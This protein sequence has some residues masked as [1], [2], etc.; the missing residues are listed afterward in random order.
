MNK[1]FKY[2]LYPNKSQEEILMKN[3]GCCRW[4]YNYYLNARQT[5][6]KN[7]EK[8]KHISES[9]LKKEFDW[10]KDAESTSLQ[11]SRIDL[12]T[13]YKNFFRKIKSK[14][15]TSLRYKSKHF[16]KRTFRIQNVRNSLRV[17]NSKIKLGKLGFIKL[18]YHRELEGIIKSATVEK[19]TNKWF[20]SIIVEC[21]ALIKL[22]STDKT[23]G[24]DLGLKEF[25]T[26]SDG[27]VIENP[28]FLKSSEEKL[29]REQKKLSKRKKGSSNRRKQQKVVAKLHEKIRNQRSD[30]LHKTSTKLVKENQIIC[31]ED[32]NVK[33]MVKNRK[34]SKSISDVSWSKFVE[35]LKYKS[36]WYGRTIVQIDRFF[37]SSKMCSH[38]GAIKEDLK[39]SDRIYKC[40]CGIEL[41]RDFNAS[42]NI[43]TVGLKTVGTTVLA[44]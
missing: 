17:E 34:L 32:L 4:I 24:I 27:I 28:K 20:V 25:V 10:L 18:K 5:A 1:A 37:P 22:P 43:L 29:K 21:D 19:N 14:D 2:R 12:E 13:A 31:L 6:Y 9:S 8:Y 44:S 23:V 42:I 39:L 36:D 40:D 35:Q 30:F 26:C 41:D 33:G 3:I 15:K 7:N 38:C 16:S 11:Q